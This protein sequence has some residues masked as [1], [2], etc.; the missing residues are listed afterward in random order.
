MIKSSVIVTLSFAFAVGLV[1][2]SD[3]EDGGASPILA[4]GPFGTGTGALTAAGAETRATEVVAGTVISA[5]RE[6][7]RGL[8]VYEVYVLT[9]EGTVVSVYIVADTG[10]ILEVE[11]VREGPVPDLQPVEGFISL[12]EAIEIALRAQSGTVVGWEL[13]PDDDSTWAYELYIRS[14]AG[15]LYEVEIDARSGAVVEVELESADDRDD[16]DDDD[17]WDNDDWDDR[18]DWED[19]ADGPGPGRSRIEAAA[20]RFVDGRVTDIDT[21]TDDGYRAWS[22]EVERTTG[23][24]VELYLLDPSLALVSAEGTDGPFDYDFDPGPAYLSLSEARAA[25]GVG[26]DLDG[27]EFEREDGRLVWTLALDDDDEVEIDAVT[28]AVLP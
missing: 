24:E 6:V 20:L 5:D 10:E 13:E 17:E 2:C 27:W 12:S 11:Q 19:D 1:A 26:G 28:G 4:N 14:A 9:A 25:A 16:W 22:V 15:Q 21:E 18:D 23:A 7:R 3:S 8:D